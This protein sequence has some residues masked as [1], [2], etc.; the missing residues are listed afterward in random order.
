MILRHEHFE[1]VEMRTICN[2]NFLLSLS[3]PFETCKKY[4]WKGKNL[5]VKHLEKDVCV[6]FCKFLAGS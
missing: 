5:V 1:F 6:F 2:I 4:I 3:F